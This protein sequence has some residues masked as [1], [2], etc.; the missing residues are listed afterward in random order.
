MAARGR[1]GTRL[2]DALPLTVYLWAFFPAL[3]TI[4][5]ISGGQQLTHDNGPLGLLLLCAGV[6]ALGGFAALEFVRLSRH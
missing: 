5:A 4:L 3:G 6:I 1:R 2:R